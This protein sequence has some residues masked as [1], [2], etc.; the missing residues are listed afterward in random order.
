MRKIAFNLL[1]MSLPAFAMAEV[2]FVIN[3]VPAETAA[4]D[5]IYFAGTLNG[6][7]PGDENYKFVKQTNG[8][9]YL[10]I[11]GTG[12]I[13]FKFTRGSWETVEG[14][15]NGNYIPNRQYTF[16]TDTVAYF[17]ITGWEGQSGSH[18]AAENV[19]IIDEEFYMPQ[20]DRN[21]RIWVYLPPDYEESTDLY[22]VLYM[23]DAQNIFDAYYSF[24]GEWEVDETLNRLHGEGVK[25]PIVVGIDNGGGERINEYSPWIH[26]NYG[27]GDGD[28]YLDFIA[29]TLKPFIDNSYRTLSDRDN[30][31]IM[32]SSMGGL[33]SFYA[34][35]KYPEL[36]SKLGV[37]SPS[38]WF[39]DSVF[40]T[41][42]DFNKQHD[43]NMYMLVG[44]LEGGSMEQ[45]FIEMHEHLLQN[46]F[47]D[48]EINAV[49][50]ADGEH[51]EWFWLRE[52]E[53]AYLW[54]FEKYVTALHDDPE[55]HTIKLSYSA[56]E[57]KL[58]VRASK[59]LKTNVRL[60]DI[61]G[62]MIVLNSGNEGVYS[63]QEITPG[64]YIVVAATK[65]A[66]ETLKLIKY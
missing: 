61:N 31:G 25:V 20:L 43:F 59:T 21:R 57:D 34:G 52:F 26:P 41:V 15:Q 18:T 32:G 14:D 33:I 5:E 46:N 56:I 6:W 36:F 51:S 64:F 1:L 8:D 13:E 62:K 53:D 29:Q 12:S 47:S 9:Y 63:L 4:E 54:M 37:F 30:T 60:F 16:G 39:N 27:G 55:T 45:D 22:P 66:S 3:Q 2:Q 11:D 19:S 38:F 40:T 65:D 7:D 23:H 42:T 58:F 10:S 35:F 49:V 48:S 17:Q 50:E 28:A 44:Q 24:I